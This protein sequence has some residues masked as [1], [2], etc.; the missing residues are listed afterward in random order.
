M[1]LQR[2]HDAMDCGPACLKM[3][4]R[5]YGRHYPLS[6]L[7]ELCGLSHAGVSVKGIGEAAEK[8]GFHTLGVSIEFSRLVKEVPL[9]CIAHWN[10][11][12]F[13]V[14]YKIT[15]SRVYV[16]DPG[17]GLLKYSHDEFKKYWSNGVILLIEP[18]PLFSELDLNEGHAHTSKKGFLFL[19]QYLAPYKKLIVQ[20]FAG[21]LVGSLL[22]LLFPFL[23]QSVVDFGINHRDLNFIYIILAAQLM[24]FF[25][26]TT[27][28]FVRNWILLHIS[29][30]VN[31]NLISDFLIKLMKL[32]ISYFDT[33]MIGDLL[34]RV[35]DHYRIEQFLTSA[36]LNVLFSVFNLIVFSAILA[37]YNMK[38]FAVFMLGSTLYAVWVSIFLKR[39]ADL[40]YKRFARMRENQDSLIQLIQGM[41]EIKLHNCEQEKRWKWEQIQA[42]LYKISMSG[43]KLNQYQQAGSFF[44]NELKNIVITFLSAQA[45]IQGEISLGMMLSIQYIIGQLNSPI[46]QMIGFVHSAQD[47]RLSLER[48]AEIHDKKDEEGLLE[49]RIQ[50]LGNDKGIHINNVTF[51]YPGMQ[52]ENV[53]QDVNIHI[54]E[55]RITAIVGMSGS[56]K[57][58]LLKLMLNFY[59]P[60]KGEIKVGPYPL[61]RISNTLWRDKC[62]VVMQEGFIFSDTIVKN[63]A[64]GAERIDN[65]FLNRAMDT[66]HIREFIE[67]LPLGLNTKIGADG[68]GLSQGQK[69]RLLIARSV[70]KNPDYIFFDE[71]TNALD[72]NNE[73]AIM[74]KLDDFFKGKTVVVVAHRLS[75]VKN[76]DQIIV[77]DRGRIVEFGTH[78]GLTRIRGNYYNLVKNQLELGN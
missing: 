25:S 74:E 14:V 5:H 32:P 21:M 12:H 19:F 58:T 29:S 43:L 61:D 39:R 68:Q 60:I 7:R 16:A 41:Q 3:I 73:K 6:F 53:L 55:G 24:L 45:V 17:H 38:I 76:A 28:D 33:K 18:T 26:R 20:L 54:P 57:T 63:I 50:E 4:S 44:I 47:A 34:Q 23:T 59:L 71:A 78:A 48:L 37:I 40:D 9:P 70:Y 72:A 2:Q 35:N 15:R 64:L 69:Q 22:L 13:T 75:T 66:A 10:Q 27:V 46:E 30:R 31:I 62:G 65:V 77:M 51:H 11:N 8:I 36:T 67:S 42:R 52:H 56:G 1:K 49:E